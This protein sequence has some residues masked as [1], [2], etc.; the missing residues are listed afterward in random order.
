MSSAAQPALVE[1]L[2]TMG[3]QTCY[4]ITDKV[5]AWIDDIVIGKRLIMAFNVPHTPEG[6]VEAERNN[7]VILCWEEIW[8]LKQFFENG[9][10]AKMV[11]SA[12][13]PGSNALRLI[14]TSRILNKTAVKVENTPL[15]G[16]RVTLSQ[17]KKFCSTSLRRFVALMEHLD[18][19]FNESA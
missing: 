9:E 18:I 12:C 19:Q 4:R 1:E 8:E 15:Y 14:L 2:Y 7:G 17:G 6:F 13:L 16:V 11:R 5:T 3:S 10:F